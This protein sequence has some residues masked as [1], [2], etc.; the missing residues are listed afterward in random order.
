MFIPPWGVPAWAGYLLSII[1][2][3]V[4]AWFLF[5]LRDPEQNIKKL[6]LAACIASLTLGLGIH[7]ILTSM[8]M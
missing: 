3:I 8:G 2:V 1:G 5:A 6:F 7:I 4:T